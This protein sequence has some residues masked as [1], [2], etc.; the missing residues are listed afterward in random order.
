MSVV[1]NWLQH[2]CCSSDQYKSCVFCVSAFCSLISS[3]FLSFPSPP[4]NVHQASTSFP[5]V[6]YLDPAFN[7]PKPNVGGGGM[8]VLGP[9][10][11]ANS[12][13]GGNMLNG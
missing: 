6:D 10:G 11:V 1:I 13:F 3:P 12:V 4:D 5:S 9:G 8:G 2:C 7:F